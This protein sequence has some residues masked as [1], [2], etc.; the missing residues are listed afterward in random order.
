MPIG[1]K[2]N[3]AC[4]LAQGEVIAHWDDDDW[5]APAWLGSQVETLL[6]KGAG[7]CWLDKVLFCAPETRRGSR[8][9]ALL[10]W[11]FQTRSR[12]SRRRNAQFYSPT[13]PIAFKQSDRKPK[14]WPELHPSAETLDL[15]DRGLVVSFQTL[16]S[17]RSSA[18]NSTGGL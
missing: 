15:S 2:R 18:S 8:S 11:G 17:W 14:K 10:I 16:S 1:A 3:I 5:M 7:I 6:S 13:K 4:E 9:K 12:G